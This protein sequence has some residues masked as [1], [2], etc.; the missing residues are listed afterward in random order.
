MVMGHRVGFLSEDTFLA[1]NHEEALEGKSFS[2]A[3]YAIK[4][5]SLGGSPRLVAR[6][7]LPIMDDS[8]GRPTFNLA[9]LPSTWDCVLSNEYPPV[10][11]DINPKY[12]YLSLAIGFRYQRTHWHVTAFIHSS[13]L[14]TLV[15][16]L[17]EDDSDDCLSIS[18]SEWN[19]A[20][21]GLTIQHRT[22]TCMAPVSPDVLQHTCIKLKKQKSG[23]SRY[24]IREQLKDR[25]G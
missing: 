21:L 20:Y 8:I 18:W 19:S 6:L 4:G 5:L 13:S 17:L 9:H 7:E 11:H 12:R 16:H 10:I 23:A 1:L 14:L 24:L 25:L 22:V 15:D 3:L 2:F